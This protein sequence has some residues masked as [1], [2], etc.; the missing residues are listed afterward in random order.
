MYCKFDNMYWE[1]GVISHVSMVGYIVR[2]VPEYASL[3][4]SPL[5]TMTGYIMNDFTGSGTKKRYGKKCINIIGGC[6]LSYC[7]VLNSEERM[8][9]VKE[10]NEVTAILAD[11]YNDTQEEKEMTKK[12][13]LEED[14]K[15]KEKKETKTLEKE[16]QVI[17][18]KSNAVELLSESVNNERGEIERDKAVSKTSVPSTELMLQYEFNDQI[19]T[20]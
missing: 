11:I 8:L 20:I 3:S 17:K 7:A 12:K 16:S 15:K 9:M 13:A 18:D 2:Q 6:I 4:L 10:G 14:K 1:R 19:V 5:H